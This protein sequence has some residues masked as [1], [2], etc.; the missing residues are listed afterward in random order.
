MEQAQIETLNIVQEVLRGV[1][2][3]VIAANP[4]G[5]EALTAM[6][7]AAATPDLSPAAQT[8]LRDL[9]AGPAMLEPATRPRQ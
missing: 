6:L 8:M 5:K 4:H 9:A 7:A 3:S 1:V 2:L